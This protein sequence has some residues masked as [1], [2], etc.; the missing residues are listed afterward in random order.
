M[1]IE[2]KGYITSRLLT[3][4]IK[5]LCKNEVTEFQERQ[6]SFPIGIRSFPG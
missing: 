5:F 6:M 4:K 1:L 3:K 2:K